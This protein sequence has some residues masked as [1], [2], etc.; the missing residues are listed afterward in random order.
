M[1]C[2][3]VRCGSGA[4]FRSQI[5]VSVSVEIVVGTGPLQVRFYAS[6][7]LRRVN[8]AKVHQA[9]KKTSETRAPLTVQIERR[10]DGL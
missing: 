8:S 5:E 10:F 7:V 9:K 1:R 3:A 2:G 4:R 6:G